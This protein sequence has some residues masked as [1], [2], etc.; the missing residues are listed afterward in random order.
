MA[1]SLVAFNG[2]QTDKD[3][4]GALKQGLKEAQGL[5][6]MLDMVPSN[7]AR[8]KKWFQEPWM[9]EVR[10]PKFG[11]T[12]KP[13]KTL[14]LGEDGDREVMR[15]VLENELESLEGVSFYIP[16]ES[17]EY[18]VHGSEVLQME[19]YDLPQKS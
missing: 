10:D 19:A 15:A 3:I 12:Y 4:V 7:Y 13:S 18:D 5:I 8:Q 2:I 17:L 11:F 9:E 6:Q 16:P 14:E 1:L